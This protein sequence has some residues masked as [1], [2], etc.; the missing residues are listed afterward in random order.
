MFGLLFLAAMNFQAKFFYFVLASLLFLCIIQRKLLVISDSLAYLLLG[1]LMAIYDYSGGALA[2]MRCVAWAAFYWVGFNLAAVKITRQE[3]RPDCDPAFAEKNGYTL[4]VVVSF[5]SFAHYI[6]NF[7]YNYNDQVG[8]NTKDIWTGEVMAATGQAA[9]ACIM[10]GLAV[11]LLFAPPKPISRVIGVLC[12]VGLMAYNLVLACRTLLV[13][14]LILLI[15]GVLYRAKTMDNAYK[16]FKLWIGV[17]LVFLI[18]MTLFAMNIFG[19]QDYVMNS[20]LFDRFGDSPSGV[21]EE[22]GRLESK[23]QFI[24]NGF[25]YPFG[26][27]HLRDQFGYAHDLWLDGYDEYGIFGFVLIVAITIMGIKELVKLIRRTTYSRTFKLTVMCV[28]VAILLEFC[29][30]PILAGMSWL[31]AC[32][33]LI[34]G[35]ITG[36]NTIYQ[37][38]IGAA[39][40]NTTN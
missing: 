13:I 25:R 37:K 32:F 30:E 4:L 12:I 35:C 18:L 36:M 33:C 39:D 7:L 6:L 8:R 3:N 31:F 24:M 27:L 15:V 20:N 2:L 19:I 14:V 17:L 11:A 34:N 21:L 9:L 26:G 22:S 5:G 23:L 1:V 28:Y 16:R 10:C 29:V 40:E 38:S